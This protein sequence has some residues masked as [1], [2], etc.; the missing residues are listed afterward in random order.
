[1]CCITD[2]IEASD[3]M[4][5]NLARRKNRA[6]LCILLLAL[7]S[8][9]CFYGAELPALRLT[10]DKICHHYYNGQ[11]REHESP[12][13]SCKISQ[14]QNKVALVVGCKTAFDAIPCKY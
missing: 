4:D 6:I 7:L 9:F 2:I 14:I 3:G 13:G 1:M 12:L 11:A 10:E 5:D 8:N